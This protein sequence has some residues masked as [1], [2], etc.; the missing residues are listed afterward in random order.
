MKQIRLGRPIEILLAEDELGDVRFSKPVVPAPFLEVVRAIEDFWLCI[1][2]LPVS[3]SVT[4][5]A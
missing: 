1:V 5:P 2:K 4:Q 3:V